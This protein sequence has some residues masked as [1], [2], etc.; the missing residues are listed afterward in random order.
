MNETHKKNR[1]KFGKFLLAKF[2]KN[3]SSGKWPFLVNTDFSA[4]VRTKPLHNRKN[5]VVW[6][7]KRSDAGNILK[8]Q[9]EKFSPGVMLWGG[10]TARG[11]IPQNAPVF[12]DEFLDEYD[13]E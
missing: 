9:E 3:G 8:N 1:V 2:G 10:V 6:A 11:L 12:C 5:N 4:F 7:K 13:F